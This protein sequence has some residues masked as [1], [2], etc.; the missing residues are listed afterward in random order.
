MKKYEV[1]LNIIKDSI[2]LSFGYCIHLRTPSFPV[3]IMPTKETEII[4]IAT[5][6]DFLPNRIL[7]KSLAEK[8]DDFLKTPKKTSKKKDG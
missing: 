6:Q 8:I 1:L 3:F 7:K 2:T 4:P 5:H